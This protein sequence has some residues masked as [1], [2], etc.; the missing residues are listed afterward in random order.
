MNDSIQSLT[1]EPPWTFT[2]SRRATAGAE[3]RPDE[4]DNFDSFDP[5]I[6]TRRCASDEKR[7]LV[8]QWLEDEHKGVGEVQRAAS[9]PLKPPN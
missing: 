2:V 6:A 9:Q 3:H 4:L 5:T 8:L 7:S 1:L